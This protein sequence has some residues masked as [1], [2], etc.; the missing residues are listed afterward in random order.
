MLSPTYCL[1]RCWCGNDGISYDRYGEGSCDF[2]CSGDTEEICGGYD[3]FNLYRIDS[4]LASPADY[5][6]CF[7]DDKLDRV[8]HNKKV[9][10]DNTPEV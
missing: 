1:H 8:L 2:A 10:D 9:I 7:A 5:I 4:D 6:G 3:A